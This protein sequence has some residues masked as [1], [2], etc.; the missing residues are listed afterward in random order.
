MYYHNW[1]RL[2]ARI[3]RR[4]IVLAEMVKPNMQF[5]DL[6]F[7]QDVIRGS[8]VEHG[9]VY[10]PCAAPH[11][12]QMPWYKPDKKGPGTERTLFVDQAAL[13]KGVRVFSN[14]EIRHFHPDYI[15]VSGSGSSDTNYKGNFLE[16][17]GSF[18]QNFP[19][20][21]VFPW[22]VSDAKAH[23]QR[24]YI[25]QGF[26]KLSDD[27]NN[28]QYT[29]CN[30]EFLKW[31]FIDDGAGNITNIDGCAFRYEVL[32]TNNT[33]FGEDVFL[34]GRQISDGVSCPLDSPPYIS[35]LDYAYGSGNSKDLNKQ[36]HVYTGDLLLK[37]L[38]SQ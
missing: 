9:H 1:L 4:N 27:D 7:V 5:L 2:A 36:Y 14:D 18:V 8:G 17:M 24:Y 31:L 3:F 35:S 10:Q 11:Y 30:G 16:A 25:M 22:A 23:W 19:S 6:Y 20:A 15:G 12:E 29:L 28:P 13:G 37:N 34:H 21:Y 26:G 32:R 38:P 33:G